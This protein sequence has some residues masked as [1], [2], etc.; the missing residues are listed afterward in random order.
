MQLWL[1]SAGIWFLLFLNFGSPYQAYH[2]PQT[3]KALKP[4]LLL[5]VVNWKSAAFADQSQYFEPETSSGLCELRERETIN[6]GVSSLSRT[7]CLAV[8]PAL[9]E[10]ESRNR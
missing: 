7:K 1:R 4:L 10:C 3:L 5:V 2:Q 6:A 8:L 9:C